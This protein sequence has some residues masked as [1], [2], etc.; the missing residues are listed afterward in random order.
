LL[1]YSM[2]RPPP[3]APLFPYTTLFRSVRGHGYPAPVPSL[4]PPPAGAPASAPNHG[5][6]PSPSGLGSPASAPNHAPRRPPAGSGAPRFMRLAHES[7]VSHAF[8]AW[9][10]GRRP[11]LGKLSRRATR[12]ARAPATARDPSRPMHGNR[13]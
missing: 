7:K 10:T 2:T 3:R 8:H 5:S 4:T 1:L 11:R 9:G 13:A 6:A 12:R